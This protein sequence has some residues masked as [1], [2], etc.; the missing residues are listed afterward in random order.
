[1]PRIHGKIRLLWNRN[2][3]FYDDGITAEP[4]AATREGFLKVAAASYIARLMRQERHP[5]DIAPGEGKEIY[6][7]KAFGLTMVAHAHIAYY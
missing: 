6:F 2:N 3:R 1:M 4:I 5:F 7:L